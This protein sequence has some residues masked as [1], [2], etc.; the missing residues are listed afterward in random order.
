MDAE[1]RPIS[2]YGELVP[3]NFSFA[4]CIFNLVIQGL[5][6]NAG[7]QDSQGCLSD[8][9]SAVQM[10]YQVELG[11][12]LEPNKKVCTKAKAEAAMDKIM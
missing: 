5:S 6:R 7:G 3:S 12:K 4:L 9:P 11:V 10:E 1:E 8:E 2:I